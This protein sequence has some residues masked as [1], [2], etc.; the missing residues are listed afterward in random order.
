MHEIPLSAKSFTEHA[1]MLDISMIN[2]FVEYANG[3]EEIIPILNQHLYHEQW[4]P[5][6]KNLGLRYIAQLIPGVTLQKDEVEMMLAEINILTNHLIELSK[7]ND[8]F[9]QTRDFSV[10]QADNLVA[11]LTKLQSEAVVDLYIS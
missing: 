5:L 6:A 9:A 8:D 4:W 3:W 2:I 7:D 1:K 11:T 10:E